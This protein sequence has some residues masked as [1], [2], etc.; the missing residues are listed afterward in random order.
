MLKNHA[1]QPVSIPA[2]SQSHELLIPCLYLLRTRITGVLGK[3]SLHSL[4]WP[5]PS[6]CYDYRREPPCWRVPWAKCWSSAL[7]AATSTI[8][9]H[10]FLLMCPG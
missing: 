1:L 8:G 3:N 2:P 9:R 7:V 5:Q 4:G 6:E 10:S